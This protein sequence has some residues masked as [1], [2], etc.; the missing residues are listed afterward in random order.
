[1]T[2]D[3]DTPERL[4][5]WLLTSVSNGGND[6][7]VPAISPDDHREALALRDAVRVLAQCNTAEPPGDQAIRGATQVIRAF[8]LTVDVDEVG[9]VNLASVD[10]GVRAL[11]ATIV[12]E[13]ATASA[14]GRWQRLKVCRSADCRWAF[15]DA[16]P[17]RVATWCS[18]SV[19]GSRSKARAYRRRKGQDGDHAPTP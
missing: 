6:V 8:T 4:R 13:V 3:L 2:D 14:V 12:A 11:L 16:S 1:G 10:P 7:D 9:S 17:A 15:Y 5:T 18:M 19:C